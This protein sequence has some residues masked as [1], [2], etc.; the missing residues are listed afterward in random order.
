MTSLA[1]IT[2]KYVGAPYKLG[3][4][5][6]TE[7]F[8]CLSLIVALARDFKKEMVQDFKGIKMD[9]DLKRM[10]ETDYVEVWISDRDKVK[11]LMF[12]FVSSLGD[13]IP[14]SKAFVGDLLI[15][16]SKRLKEITI[17]IH[18]GGD[19][20]LSA[21]TNAGV[22]LAKMSLFNIRAAYKWKEKV[23]QNGYVT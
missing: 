3:G 16:E 15:L 5:S 21:F 2:A 9:Q 12:D 8:D 10:I 6:K 14:P 11:Q 7:G 18:A 23:K 13:P 17:G 22:K 4:K 19:L 20:I 1:R